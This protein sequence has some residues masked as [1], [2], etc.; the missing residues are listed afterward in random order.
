[1]WRLL[2]GVARDEGVDAV[3]AAQ[4]HS[5][6]LAEES[7]AIQP[8]FL[9]DRPHEDDLAREG[10]R[11]DATN[12]EQQRG[13]SR[14]VIAGSAGDP[15]AQESIRPLIGCEAQ[16]LADAARHELGRV[17]P[18]PGGESAWRTCAATE[19]GRAHV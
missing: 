6:P 14:S 1:M 11:I 5:M 3:D 13:R 16:A 2:R 9:L 10:V 7:R 8:P 15:A 12:G 4:V 19:I 18:E 17:E